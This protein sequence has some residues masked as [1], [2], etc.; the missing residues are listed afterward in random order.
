MSTPSNLPPRLA[1][2]MLRACLHPADAEAVLGDLEEIYARLLNRAGRTEARRWYWSQ[3]LRSMPRFAARTLGWTFVMLKTYLNIALRNFRREKGYTFINVF[4]LALGIGCALLMFLHVQDELRYDRFHTNADRI[5]RVTATRGMPEIRISA[6][7][8]LPTG[9]ALKAEFPEV[10]EAV[11]A[12]RRAGPILRYLDRQFAESNVYA[13]DSTFLE[14]FS[15]PLVKGDRKKSL[16]RPDAIVVTE[17]A[18]RRYFGTADPIG[19]TLTY[20]TSLGRIDLTVTGVLQD[21]PRQSHIHFDFLVPFE[22]FGGDF[23]DD[24]HIFVSNYTYLL[25]PNGYDVEQ[26]A[27]KLP[28]FVNRHAGSELDPGA[29]YRLGLQPLTDI[30]LHSDL[31]AEAEP[32]GDIAYVYLFSAVAFFIL[33][34]AC[35]NF[36]NLTTAR[37]GQRA[38]EVG[39][40][41]VIGAQ[42][43]QLVLQFLGESTLLGLAALFAGLV[44]LRAALPVFNAFTGKALA[45]DLVGNGP[46]LLALLGIVVFVGV[47]AGA[48]PALYL[49]S[50]R[51]AAVL[52]GT[53]SAGRPRGRE[54][55]VVFQFAT[56]IILLICTGVVFQQL[57]YVQKKDV[58]FEKQQIVVIK[59]DPEVGRQSEAIK[60]AFLQHPDV[61]AASASMLVPSTDL[62]TY[63]VRVEATNEPMTLGT[64]K[65]DTEFLETYGMEVVAGRWFSRTR[66]VDSTATVLNE[67]AA[68]R[69]GFANPQ[70]AIGTRLIWADRKTVD[71][72]GVIR[73]FHV[74]SLREQIEPMLFLLE[75]DYYYVSARLQSEN[76]GETL[77]FLEKTLTSFAPQRPFEY[78]FV[79]ERFDALHR[80]DR[81][82]G[83]VFGAFALIATIIACLGLFGL[84]AFTAARRTREVGVRKVLGASVVSIIALLSKEFTRLVVIAI[85]IAVPLGYLAM[86]RWLDGFAYR[87]EISAAVFAAAALTALGI[88]FL[89]VSYQALRAATIDP[90][91]SLR[92]N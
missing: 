36:V 65:V 15:F 37:S 62:W 51:P 26:L 84:A 18:A 6:N 66:P 27:A 12:R 70:D 44:V 55:L 16:D 9:P 76:A 90:V 57:K 74:R 22:T 67:E 88:A 85:V 1:Q 91:R 45:M 11:R 75:S 42:R 5:V 83:Q 4:G 78:F 41:K 17:S 2:A 80:T 69:L 32:N 7:T 23:T 38:R 8:A 50:F 56:S 29:I 61:D 10:L 31:A 60:A 54:S 35:V 58:G 86:Q 19:K 53:F 68:R 92:H 48:Y 3:V 28:G 14:V 13:V 52:K 71:V 63:G 25:L 46:M 49:S 40:R 20:Q 79:D 77:A 30:H 64:Y 47:A 72:I 24:W 21:L 81:Q 73:D 82:I 39:M 33:L 87:V 43:R 59:I 89:T 34:I